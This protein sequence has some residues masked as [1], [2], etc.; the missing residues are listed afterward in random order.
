MDPLTLATMV[1]GVL[2]PYVAKA[3]EELAKQAGGAAWDQ[4]NTIYDAIKHKLVGDSY[5]EQT[6]QRLESEPGSKSRQ[7]ALE[8]VLEEKIKADPAF[9]VTLQTL[10]E[11]AKDSG[12]EAIT[13][14]VSVSDHARTGDISQIGTVEGGVDMSKRR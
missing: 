3:S 13:Q 1:V 9:A 6:L 7:A 2:A 11:Q 8:G 5:A 4:L 14:R 10:L 12:A